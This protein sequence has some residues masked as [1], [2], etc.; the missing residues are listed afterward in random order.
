MEDSGKVGEAS[1]GNS[2][3]TAS[4]AHIGPL[5]FERVH[6]RGDTVEEEDLAWL[7]VGTRG[8]I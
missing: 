7:S 6:P 2:S 8:K 1:A 5:V 4:R 3:L